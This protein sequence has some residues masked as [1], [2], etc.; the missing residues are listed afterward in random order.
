MW[1]VLSESGTLNAVLIQETI[2]QFWSSR[3]PFEGIESNSHY[4]PRC[5]H[6]S[7]EEGHK[8]WL[9]LPKVL[10]KEGIN[11]FELT[12]ILKEILG[13]ATKKER[14]NI[15]DTVWEGF[16]KKPTI[17]ELDTAHLLWGYP[18]QPYYNRESD[19]VIIPDF[20]R[21]AWPYPR[22]TSFTT[23]VGTVMSRMR[24]F[25]RRYE[26]RI[27]KV[28]YKYD[29]VLNEKID[30]FYDANS[31]KENYTEPPCI[32]GGDVQIIDEET[33]AIGIGQRSTFTGFLKTAEHIIKNDYESKLKY[34]CAVKLA[35]FPATDF[36]HL[37]VT[38]NWPDSNTAL[39]MPY[40]YESKLIKEN[41]PKKL[42]LKT[43]E[44]IRQQSEFYNRPLQKLVHPNNFI[45]SGLCTIFIANN[46]K[47]ELYEKKTSFLDFLIG[48][49]KLETDKIIWVGGYPKKENDVKHLYGSLREQASGASNIFTVK[50]KK[51]IAYKRNRLTNEELRNHGIKVIEWSDSYLDLLGGPHCSINPLS[52]EK[53][54]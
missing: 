10:K 33:I 28:A 45:E 15:I 9:E 11:V 22:D 34:I 53:N 47:L 30:L 4:T 26:P 21:A 43:L 52:R 36:M 38:I 40:F 27:V 29:S 37:D 32:E 51:V 44:A 18:D 5:P 8:E 12:E 31:L 49:G 16:Q 20:R 2:K 50:R 23:P 54:S 24:R 46:E 6:P 35:D 41:P 19:K 48:K 1:R 17:E 42:F 3:L 39:I 14:K 13:N 7:F 25:S